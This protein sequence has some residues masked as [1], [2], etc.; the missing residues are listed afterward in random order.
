MQ[1]SSCLTFNIAHDKPNCFF[2]FNVA[3]TWP[4]VLS[5][6]S[7]QPQLAQPYRHL[8]VPPKQPQRMSSAA[9]C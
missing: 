1:Q 2:S 5:S 4:T 3:N 9:D 8:E 6:T 7:P